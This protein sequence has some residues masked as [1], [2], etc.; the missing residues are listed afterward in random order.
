MKDLNK[1][2]DKITSIWNYTE[3]EMS[4]FS[5]LGLKKHLEKISDIVNDV[6]CEIEELKLCSVCNSEVCEPCLEDIAKEHG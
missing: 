6:L 1:I 3:L 5:T 4:D 2:A